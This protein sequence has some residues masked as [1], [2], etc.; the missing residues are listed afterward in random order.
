MSDVESLRA[1]RE[2][3]L[4]RLLIRA[5]HTMNAELGKRIRAR[6][7]SDFQP[8]FTAL[9]GHLDTEGTR[10]SALA[11]R[12]GTSRQAVSQL[13]QQIEARGYVERIPDPHDKRAVIARHTH[14]GRRLLKAAIETMIAIESEYESALGRDGLPRLKDLLKRLLDQVD[15]VDPVGE[16]GLE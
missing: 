9:L 7:F 12:M 10:I 16:L 14:S 15:Q 13:L 2:R 3:M 6:G 4:L 8:S 11:R 5:T 1:T